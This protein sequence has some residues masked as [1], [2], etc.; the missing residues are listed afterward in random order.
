MVCSVNIVNA[1]RSKLFSKQGIT[2][3]YYSIALPAEN[4]TLSDSFCSSAE[5]IAENKRS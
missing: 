3:K 4:F 2:T 1:A 5:Q